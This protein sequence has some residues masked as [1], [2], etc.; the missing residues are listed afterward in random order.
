MTARPRGPRVGGRHAAVLRIRPARLPPRHRGPSCGR[1]LRRPARPRRRRRRRGG[2]RASTSSSSSR[3]SSSPASS[4]ASSSAPGGSRCRAS[5]PRRDQAAD[6]P[7][8]TV[9]VP[10]SSPSSLL[11]SPVDASGIV[12]SDVWR[13]G[14]YAMNW[15]LRGGGRLLRRGRRRR[16]LRPLLVARGRGAVLP[17]VAAAAARRHVGGAAARRSPG[18]LRAL[19]HHR[20]SLA[21]GGRTS[22]HRA[23]AGVLLAPARG[24]GS[25]RS[26]GCWRSC[27][28]AGGSGRRSAAAAAWSGAAAI[29]AA[30]LVFERAR[31]CRASPRCCRCSAPPRSSRPGRAPGRPPRRALLMA[32][33]PRFVGRI[34]YAWYIWHWPALVFA[35]A[36]WGAPSAG[37]AVVISLPRSCRPCSRTAGSR[38]RCGARRRTSRPRA[39]LLATL[40][41]PAAPWRRASR[42]RGQRAVGAAALAAAGRGRGPARPHRRDPAVGD[43]AAAASEGRERRSRPPY[44]DGCLVDERALTLAGAASTAPA[45][46]RL[47]RRAVRRLARDAAV[48]GARARRPAPPLAPRGADEGRLP[49][50]GGLRRLAAAR[51]ALPRVRRVARVRAARGSSARSGRRSCWRR[52]P[53][54]TRPDGRQPARRRRRRARA[55]GGWRPVLR[56]LRAAAP[57]ASR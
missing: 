6:A 16:P 55:R 1:H 42:S 49:A 5:T 22:P 47:D 52:A 46:R 41:G 15:R 50:V 8:L 35:A 17:R 24:R 18:V 36:A 44:D 54:T 29:A 21:S 19:S 14:A 4:S 3:A 7:G 10:W 34:S 9:I 37:E 13:R 40:A 39:I 25:S 48:P 56:R 2:F 23:R 45:A 20:R 43:G 51:A 53:R 11:L 33:V 30:T 26:A 57:H 32:R 28:P 27:S 12:A 38:S 31:R